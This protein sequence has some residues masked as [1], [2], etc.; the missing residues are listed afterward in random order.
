MFSSDAESKTMNKSDAVVAAANIIRNIGDD[1]GKH[2]L[3]FFLP[4]QSRTIFN[5]T[6]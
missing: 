4:L 6:V 3:F 1:D 2:K 5:V